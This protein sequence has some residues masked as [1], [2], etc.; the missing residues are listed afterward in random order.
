MQAALLGFK[1]SR[2]GIESSNAKK[3]S[4]QNRSILMPSGFDASGSKSHPLRSCIL[5]INPKG[6]P[7]MLC[8]LIASELNK[9]RVRAQER[10]AIGFQCDGDVIIGIGMGKLGSSVHGDQG[11][12]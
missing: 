4:N 5:G 10:I 3:P 2:N 9:F 7:K 8:S 12:G 6:K 1:P 11:S